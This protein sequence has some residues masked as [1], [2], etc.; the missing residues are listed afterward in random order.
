[1]EIDNPLE[2]IQKISLSMFRKNFFGIFHGSISAKIGQNQFLVNKK[3]AIFDNIQEKDMILLHM[4][5][6]YRWNEASGDS[7]IHLS[8]YKN[9]KEAKYIC[10]CMPPNTLA[11]SLQND[12][13]VPK[14][15][16]GFMRNKTIEVYDPKKFDDWLER[17]PHEIYRFLLEKKIN[18]IVI[19]GYGVWSYAKS[20]TELAKNIAVI[21]NTTRLLNII[22]KDFSADL[23]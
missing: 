17:A 2:A 6:D 23:I 21:E 11:Y 20:A 5:K 19:R 14:D 1:M 8:I 9:I 3:N 7:D 13:I 4:K 22:N 18:L 16:F 12:F 10:Y 15:Y